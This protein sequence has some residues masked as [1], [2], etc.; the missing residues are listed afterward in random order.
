MN[1]EITDDQAR[2]IYIALLDRAASMRRIPVSSGEA[3]KSALALFDNRVVRA[4]C[5]PSERATKEHDLI[6]LN[7]ALAEN[8]DRTTRALLSFTGNTEAQTLARENER[9]VREAKS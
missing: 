3:V 5:R 9:L 6:A 2:E 1:L 4:S 8:L 7:A